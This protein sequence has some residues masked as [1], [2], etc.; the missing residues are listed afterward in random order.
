MFCI[1]IFQILQILFKSSFN[2]CWTKTAL[3][4]MT[5]LTHIGFSYICQKVNLKF[6]VYKS[7]LGGMHLLGHPSISSTKFNKMLIS[8]YCLNCPQVLLTLDNLRNWKLQKDKPLK[9][10]K[11]MSS[12][13]ISHQCSRFVTAFVKLLSSGMHLRNLRA[14]HFFYRIRKRLVCK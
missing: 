6:Q 13:R 12:L 5:D 8:Y 10:S 14:S 4:W 2:K 11:T 9:I 7:L 1:D 3:K